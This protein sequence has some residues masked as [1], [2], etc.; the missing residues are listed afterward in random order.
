MSIEQVTHVLL[1]G[2]LWFMRVLISIIV[3]MA[4]KVW[5]GVMM[6]VVSGVGIQ[7]SIAYVRVMATSSKRASIG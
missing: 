4:G 7:S 3:M 6:A 2:V 1:S 5:V